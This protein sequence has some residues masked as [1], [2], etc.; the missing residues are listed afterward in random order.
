MKCTPRFWS[1]GTAMRSIALPV[2]VAIA[3]GLLASAPVRAEG[4]IT[5]QRDNGT[6]DTYRDVAIKVIHSALYLTSADGKGTIV[7]NR[8][9]CAY[10]GDTL[11]CLPTSVTLVQ[12]GSTEVVDLSNGTV[13]ANMTDQPQQL[14]LSTQHLPPH[15]ILLSITTKKGTSINLSGTIDKVTK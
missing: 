12:N 6:A 8:A 13:Y 4:T 11:V 2:F 7:I 10:Q 5:I 9:A 3:C 15:S 14:S 1:W